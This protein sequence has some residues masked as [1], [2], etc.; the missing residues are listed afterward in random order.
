MAKY[1]ASSMQNVQY[2]S[3]GF[4]IIPVVEPVAFQGAFPGNPYAGVSTPQQ[5]I[6]GII[7]EA[8]VEPRYK[9]VRSRAGHCTQPEMGLYRLM[10]AIPG[11]T[12][13]MGGQ[14]M[15]VAAEF[16]GPIAQ[17]GIYTESAL[18]SVGLLPF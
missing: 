8:A 1:Y 7:Q 13:L 15:R 17:P 6:L 18:Q 11:S 2:R 10:Q 12:S 9:I 4:K 3:P 16:C 5:A 14:A